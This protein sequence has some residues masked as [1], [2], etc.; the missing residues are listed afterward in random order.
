MLSFQKLS[1]GSKSWHEALCYIWADKEGYFQKLPYG[2]ETSD[3]PSEGLGEMFESES[4]MCPG[5]YLLRAMGA[6]RRVSRVQTPTPNKFGGSLGLWGVL[7][8]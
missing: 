7:K 8:L 2:L 6:E 5:I 1:L 4:D 3:M